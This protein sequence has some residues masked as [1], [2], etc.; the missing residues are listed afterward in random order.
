MEFVSVFS[1]AWN[2][3]FAW[4][5]GSGKSRRVNNTPL[6]VRILKTCLSLGNSKFINYLKD[7]EGLSNI[8][9]RNGL[10]E[11]KRDLQLRIPF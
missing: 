10:D 7:V 6:Q 3:Q 1:L 4:S 8:K 5:A 2:R 11:L 9:R